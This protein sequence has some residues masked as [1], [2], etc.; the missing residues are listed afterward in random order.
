MRSISC[1]RPSIAQFKNNNP[2][3]V[4]QLAKQFGKVS[5]QTGGKENYNANKTA[6][7]KF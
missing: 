4:R 2:G 1:T 6:M 3:Y 5:G 7:E